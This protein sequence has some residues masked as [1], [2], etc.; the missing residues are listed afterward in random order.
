MATVPSPISA[1][2]R[3]W[4]TPPLPV[5]GAPSGMTAEVVPG[6]LCATGTTA[7]V[8]RLARYVVGLGV[9]ARAETPELAMLVAE[10]AQGALRGSGIDAAMPPRP[11][12]QTE[13]SGPPG[14]SLAGA[15]PV[16]GDSS[17]SW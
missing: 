7:G 2:L 3:V 5:P 6:G 16:D 4:L 9:A 15:P 10:L 14:P 12:H 11:D 13:R 1:S 17:R 8:L